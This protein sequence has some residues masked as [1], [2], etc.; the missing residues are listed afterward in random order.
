[1]KKLTM[2]ALAAVFSAS[3]FAQ[4]VYKQL[5]KIKDYKE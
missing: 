2:L 1:M 5:S 3:A 4:D